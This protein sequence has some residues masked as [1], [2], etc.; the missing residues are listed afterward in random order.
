MKEEKIWM[1]RTVIFSMFFSC[2]IIFLFSWV[3]CPQLLGLPEPDL[4]IP[5][6]LLVLKLEWTASLAIH[7]FVNR[8]QILSFYQHKQIDEVLEPH[9]H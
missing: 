8:Q 9:W 7:S 2:D 1:K 5:Y 3:F 4:Y 6:I